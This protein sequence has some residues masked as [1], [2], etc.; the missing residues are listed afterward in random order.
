MESF[1]SCNSLGYGVIFKHY[2]HL[3]TALLCKNLTEET[4]YVQ[5]RSTYPILLGG[6]GHFSSVSRF[7]MEPF[8][9]P[10]DLWNEL[11]NWGTYQGC[12]QGVKSMPKVY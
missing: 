11:Q 2:L 5:T 8:K 7:P 4:N 12:Y 10:T 6:K 1:P 3:A 9:H